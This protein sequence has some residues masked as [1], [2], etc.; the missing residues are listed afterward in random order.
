MD[1]ALTG[2]SSAELCVECGLPVAS[3]ASLQQE[4]LLSVVRDREVLDGS[5]RDSHPVLAATPPSTPPPPPPPHFEVGWSS[6]L[7]LSREDPLSV[8]SPPS[9]DET[10]LSSGSDL[11]TVI[12]VDDILQEQ[13]L[14]LEKCDQVK[15]QDKN[16]STTSQG[17]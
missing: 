11:S 3:W 5:G 9:C 4:V 2:G 10:S 1:R 16:N 7:Y 6:D 17:R 14:F 12:C 13:I 15:T 8:D